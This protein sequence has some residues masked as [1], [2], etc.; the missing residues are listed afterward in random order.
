[1]RAVPEP[2]PV[3]PKDH[4]SCLGKRDGC[5]G[6]PSARPVTSTYGAAHAR[7]VLRLTCE[8]RLTVAGQRRNFT[9][10]PLDSS[11]SMKL[12]C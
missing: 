11:V 5:F 8:C 1:M 10:L 6:N 9:E 12:C 3:L 2:S 7:Q 4:P